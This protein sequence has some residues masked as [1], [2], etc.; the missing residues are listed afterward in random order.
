MRDFV[1]TQDIIKGSIKDLDE[2]DRIETIMDYL[3][4]YEAAKLADIQALIEHIAPEKRLSV[5]YKP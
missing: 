2:E 5:L 4:E 1:K 3:A